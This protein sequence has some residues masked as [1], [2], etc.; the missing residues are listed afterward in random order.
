MLLLV[1]EYRNSQTSVHLIQAPMFPLSRSGRLLEYFL[2]EGGKLTLGLGRSGYR[3]EVVE[4]RDSKD[5]MFESQT[6]ND[7]RL[8]HALGF[9]GSGS[10]N[11]APK[12]QHSHPQSLN[13][14]RST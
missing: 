12:L 10:R 7:V 1:V 13:P 3:V 5:L 14:K 2:A 8:V 4:F 9:W 11:P 6:F